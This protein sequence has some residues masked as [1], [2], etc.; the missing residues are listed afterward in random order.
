MALTPTVLTDGMLIINAQ[1]ISDHSNKIEVPVTVDVQ[2]DTAFGAGWKARVGGLKDA[3]L[4]VSLFNDFTAAQLDSIMWPLLGTVV[5]FE[6]RPTSAA[7]SA[8]NP[9]YTGSILIA[10]WTPI[11]GSV[12][13]LV[14]LDMSFPTSGAVLRQTT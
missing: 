6:V 9:A 5:T 12:G 14:Q 13:Q 7:R 11:T 4:N 2:E 10:Q 3:M 1:T 8:T